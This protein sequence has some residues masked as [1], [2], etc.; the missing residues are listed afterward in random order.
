MKQDMDGEL[1]FAG[2]AEATEK[3][4]HDRRRK[5]TEENPLKL[6]VKREPKPREREKVMMCSGETVMIEAVYH[7]HGATL[8]DLLVVRG[9]DKVYQG[10]TF[11]L[12][13]A[14]FE[15]NKLRSV[16]EFEQNKLRSRVH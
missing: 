16:A 2:S 9:T 6:W 10:V 1:E 8:Y 14:E 15:R 11:I 7:R 4:T 13:A 3:F 12:S 5:P